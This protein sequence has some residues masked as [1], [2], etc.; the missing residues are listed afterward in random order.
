MNHLFEE[1]DKSGSFWQYMEDE[2]ER[3]RKKITAIMKT[4]FQDG[5][6]QSDTEADC[7]KTD[8]NA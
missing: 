2:E 3:K 1:L 5:T 4:I 7:I 8:W 6:F